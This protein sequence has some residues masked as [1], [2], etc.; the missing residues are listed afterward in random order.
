MR[1][2]SVIRKSWRRKRRGPRE[3]ERIQSKCVGSQ[4]KHMNYY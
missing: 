3:T 4:K 2:A 1:T